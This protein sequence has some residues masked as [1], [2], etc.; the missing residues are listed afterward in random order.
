MT[1]VVGIEF[2]A[3]HFSDEKACY[4][5]LAASQ[6][7]DLGRVKGFKLRKNGTSRILTTEKKRPVFQWTQGYGMYQSN[8]ITR[9]ISTVV[10][11]EAHGPRFDPTQLP[12]PLAKNVAYEREKAER[13][14]ER[15]AK[16]REAR[17]AKEAANPKPP[18]D[19]KRKKSATGSNKKRKTETHLESQYGVKL[20]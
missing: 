9:P 12:T 10:L 5:W 1:Q 7:A 16:A 13:H 19:K 17:L 11:V 6:W 15:V 20:E 4:S 18:K 3:D 14:A 8:C 2:C